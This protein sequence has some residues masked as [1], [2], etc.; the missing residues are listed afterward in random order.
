MQTVGDKI[1]LNQGSKYTAVISASENKV[2]VSDVSYSE[3]DKQFTITFSNGSTEDI[4]ID[5][6]LAVSGDSFNLLYID[7]SGKPADSDISKDSVFLKDSS[8]QTVSSKVTFKDPI[9]ADELRMASSSALLTGTTS[10][11]Y[12]SGDTNETSDDSQAL[13]LK[14]AVLELYNKLQDQIGESNGAVVEGTPS[15]IIIYDSEGT[16]LAD[17]GKAISD[18]LLL[19]SNREQTV[20]SDLDVKES[21]FSVTGTTLSSAEFLPTDGFFTLT[22]GVSVRYIR[23]VP[24]SSSSGISLL[25]HDGVQTLIDAANIN[26]VV[27]VKKVLAAYD[28]STSEPASRTDGDRYINTN[29]SDADSSDTGQEITALAIVEWDGTGSTWVETIPALGYSPLNENTGTYWRLVSDDSA[30]DGKSWED[31]GVSTNDHDTAVNVKGTDGTTITASTALHPVQAEADAVFGDGTQSASSYHTHDLADSSA[32]GMIPAIPASSSNQFLK[33]TNTFE[34]V[35][36]S[37]DSLLTLSPTSTDYD[38]GN[39]SSSARGFRVGEYFKY[40]YDINGTSNYSGGHIVTLPAQEYYLHGRVFSNYGGYV[41]FEVSMKSFSDSIYKAKVLNDVGANSNT[42][43]GLGLRVDT[44]GTKIYFYTGDIRKKFPSIDSALGVVRLHAELSIKYTSV[45]TTR[46]LIIEGLISSITPNFS[47]SDSNL[48]GT[49]NEWG[50]T[51]NFTDTATFSEI[52]MDGN[53]I[54]NGNAIYL[55]NTF[56]ST[57][58]DGDKLI[59]SSSGIIK[60]VKQQTQSLTVTGVISDPYDI[61]IENGKDV[62]LDIDTSTDASTNLTLTNMTNGD[63]MF[64]KMYF[65]QAVALDITFPSSVVIAGETG[66]TYNFN[67]DVGDEYWISIKLLNSTYNVI[68]NKAV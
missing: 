63:E 36:L 17:S 39:L 8:S 28:F 4:P 31:P 37:N 45:P 52:D 21:N 40:V 50:G 64:I 43:S 67:G 25:T 24:D 65:S 7:P 59:Y 2:L 57:L 62:Y 12:I 27:W 38:I 44:L 5:S 41:E 51:Q 32:K 47:S 20:Q 14:S 18:L 3:A 58:S 30:P 33:D 11:K 53:D 10:A 35:I 42:T 9:I 49:D 1:D 13:M 54:I 22:N 68:I 48:L 55:T 34:D 56:I 16:A 15:N 19:K 6:V 29:T 66:S 46:D 61:D 23:T 60:D 26:S